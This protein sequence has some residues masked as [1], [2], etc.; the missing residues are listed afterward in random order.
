MLPADLKH[1][2]PSQRESDVEFLLALLGA[3]FFGWA[4]IYVLAWVCK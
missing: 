3:A 4:V 1:Y 2:R